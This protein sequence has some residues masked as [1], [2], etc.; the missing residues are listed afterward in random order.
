M[1]NSD[2][3]L[4]QDL[5]VVFGV[6]AP[7]V[8]AIEAARAVYTWRT[9]DEELAQLVFDSAL[10]E[11]VGVRATETDRQMTFES[12]AVNIEV[13]IIDE[14]AR[15]L[16]GQLDPPSVNSIE[17]RHGDDVWTTS[18][19]EIGR[20]MFDGI[21]TGPLSIRCVLANGTVITTEWT[22]F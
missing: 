2:D 8:A 20:F 5:G 13:T 1:K 3:K 10:D 16:I 17:L 11:L 6:D 15:R 7:P 12:P 18:A 22:L 4:M 14:G 21:P 9:I 19:D